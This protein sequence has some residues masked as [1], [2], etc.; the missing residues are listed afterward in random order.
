MA[1]VVD[2]MV[3]VGVVV[4]LIVILGKTM[5]HKMLKNGNG[6]RAFSR[7]IPRGSASGT[8][9][10]QTGCDPCM[11]IGGITHGLFQ[12]TMPESMGTR[13]RF[14]SRGSGWPG[15]KNGT[16]NDD[17]RDQRSRDRRVRIR[18]DGAWRSTLQCRQLWQQVRSCSRRCDRA[19]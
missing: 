9:F 17:D 10:C 2:H 15:C 6:R 11:F 4:L 12:A 3:H 13:V 8:A 16:S 18:W 5:H 19:R 1:A 7:A 14:W